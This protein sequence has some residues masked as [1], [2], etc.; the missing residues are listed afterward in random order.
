MSNYFNEP[1][2][3]GAFTKPA[4]GR[5]SPHRH[6]RDKR[7]HAIFNFIGLLLGIGAAWFAFDRT[8]SIALPIFVFVL[9]QYFVGRGIG[10]VVTDDKKVKRFVYFAMPVVFMSGIVFLTYQWWGLMWLATLL[11]FFVGGVLWALVA[12]LAMPDI[13]GEEEQD[14]AERMEEARGSHH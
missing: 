7:I 13:A 12:A 5:R 6:E 9:V 10:D 14:N 1:S 2:S 11:G 8:S 3:Y 4:L